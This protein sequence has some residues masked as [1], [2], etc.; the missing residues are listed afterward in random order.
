MN[1]A[2][3]QALQQ[4]AKRR[5]IALD[6]DGAGAD[7][8][9]R[10]LRAI[11]HPRQTEMFARR[12]PVGVL[13]AAMRWAATTKSRRAGATTA[14][15]REFLA[16]GLEQPGFR[17]TYATTTRDEA[18]DR[19]WLNDNKSGFFDVVLRYGEPIKHPTLEAFKI[20][21]V[22]IEV[23]QADLELVFSNGSHIELFGA[24]NIRSH[25][26]KRGNAKH[27]FWVDE[28]QDFPDL[29][30]FFDAVVLGTLT[31]TRGEAWFTGTPGKDCAGLFYE[32]TKQ[33]EDGDERVPNWE[34]VEMSSAD[35]PFF[36]RVVAER[37]QF[38]VEDNAKARSGPYDSEAE[39][40][41]AARDIRWEATAGAAKR[42]KNWKGDE[43]DFVRE[44][45]GRWVKTD[46]RFVYPV[47]AVPKHRLIYAPQRLAPNPFVGTHPR[48][49]SHP[50]WFDFTLAERDLPRRPH[51]RR[52]E[53]QWLYVL[54]A[55]FGY[56]P[57]PFAL[58]LWA[59]TP[60]LPEVFEMFSWKM[61]RVHTDDQ[62]AYLKLVWDVTDSIVGVVGD[63]AGKRDDFDMWRGRMGIPIEE[64]NKQGKSTLEEFLADDIRRERVH[65]RENSPLHLEMKHL[66]YLP[67]KPGKERQVFKHRVVGGVTHGDHNCDA[68]RYG[69]M[70]LHH[71][72]AK[73]PSDKPPPGSPEHWRREE[74]RE[75]RAVENEELKRAMALA[76][77]DETNHTY[78][79]ETYGNDWG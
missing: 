77:G 43:P 26:K 72:L 51:G 44:W 19:A 64:A 34:V 21:G 24:D 40:E 37:G 78:W 14:G 49:D 76:D 75:Q 23:R 62:G 57:D 29:E 27:V 73:L 61:T 58:V 2:S 11:C 22:T 66:V 67:T 54:G 28:C 56:N 71:Y 79:N 50:P 45:L 47:H 60:E 30:S 39:A 4:L 55:D 74:E 15:V 68:A 7:E 20:G 53:Y 6:G 13:P 48:F 46:A 63:P 42:A 70:Y 18:K 5:P 38:Y 52:R 25:R 1:A 41:Q 32:I 12:T 16:R 3:R 35:N 31:D 65:L 10:A 59:F 36:G 69:Y 8:A 33:E 17:G 9:A